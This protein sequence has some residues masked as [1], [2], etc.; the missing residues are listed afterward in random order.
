MKTMGDKVTTEDS[1]TSCLALI[2][3]LQDLAIDLAAGSYSRTTLE[4]LQRNLKRRV[5]SVLGASISIP[6]GRVPE[7][8]VRLD[9]VT[10]T[11]EPEEIAAALKLPLAHLLSNTDGFIIFYAAAPIAFVQLAADLADALRLEAGEVDQHP[12]LPVEPLHPGIAGLQDFTAVNQAVG[13][14]MGRGLG[15]DEAR[16][17]LRRRAEE[18]GTDL[19]GAAHDVRTSYV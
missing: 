15:L 7:V 5:P 2:A 4:M 8:A 11:V 6:A 3:D 18:A 9:L 13:V 12:R 14:L 17:E 10:R 19:V 16:A 1:T